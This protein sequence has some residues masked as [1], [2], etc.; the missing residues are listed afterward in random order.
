[1]SRFQVLQVVS[2]AI[3]MSADGSLDLTLPF[4]VAKLSHLQ[5]PSRKNDSSVLD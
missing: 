5:A 1:M 4:R 3:F 2:K